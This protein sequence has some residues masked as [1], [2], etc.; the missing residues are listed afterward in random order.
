MATAADITDNIFIPQF[1]IDTGHWTLDSDDSMYKHFY[2][3]IN[4]YYI[5]LRLYTCTLYRFKPKKTLC[6]SVYKL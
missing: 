2:L 3:L 6:T 5:K 1:M 4:L